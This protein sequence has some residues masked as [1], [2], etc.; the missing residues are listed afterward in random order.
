MPKTVEELFGKS[1]LPAH[2]VTELCKK[3]AYVRITNTKTQQ[4]VEVSFSHYGGAV[5]VLNAFTESL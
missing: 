5:Q 1:T 2:Y 4:T 3:K